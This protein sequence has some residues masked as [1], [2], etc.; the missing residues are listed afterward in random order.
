MRSGRACTRL[1]RIGWTG[2]PA[3]G[4]IAARRREDHGMA[5]M[6]RFWCWLAV[7]LALLALAAWWRLRQAG[8]PPIAARAADAGAIAAIQVPHLS[9]RDPRW[10]FERIAGETFDAVGCTLCCIALAGRA[11]GDGRS[12]VQVRDDLARADGLTGSGLVVWDR[13]VLS[14]GHRIVPAPPS[15]AAIASGLAAGRPA[16]VQ[17]RLPSG[18][19]H[20]LLVVGREDGRYLVHDPLDDAFHGR[21]LDEIAPMITGLRLLTP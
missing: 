10:R 8:A 19:A 15:H 1:R 16:I 17:V 4:W 9:Q 18:I 14:G 12:P 5:A 20:W 11:V 13:I 7:G 2:K 6:R 3:C 21:H